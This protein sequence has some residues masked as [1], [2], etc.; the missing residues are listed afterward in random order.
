MLTHFH[1]PTRII[2]LATLLALTP[3]AAEAVPVRDADVGLTIPSIVPGRAAPELV[4]ALTLL[5]QGKVDECI[6]QTRAYLRRDPGSAPAH[7]L[8]GA[9]LALKGDLAGAVTELR[10]AV[11]LN[12]DQHTAH[13][14]LGDIYLVQ[15][16]SAEAR[17]EFLRAIEI[18]DAD[19]RAHQRLGRLFESE[20]NFRQA[21]LHFEKGIVGTPAEYVG[22]KLNLGRLYNLTGQFSGSA[23][24]LEPVVAIHPKHG[25][26]LLTLGSAY[27][28]LRRPAD[29]VRL[30]RTAASVDPTGE[31]PRVYLGMALRE[32]GAHEESVQTLE[33]ARRRHL[34]SPLP[35]LQLGE[36]FV[37]MGQ[38]AKA[39]ESFDRAA[40]LSADPAP[41]RR[42]IAEIHM[43][44]KRFAEA[45]AIY[46]A[47]AEARG[48]GV[49]AW[50]RLGTAY[51]MAGRLPDAEKTFKQMATAFPGTPFPHYRLGTFYGYIKKY[52]RAEAELRRA[53]A[54]APADGSILRALSMS[55]NE[56]GNSSA[57]VETARRLVSVQPDDPNAHFYLATLYHDERRLDSAERLYREILARWPD[58]ALTLNNL[59]ALLADQGKGDE[60]VPLAQKAVALLPDNGVI[61][62]TLGW[63][64]HKQRKSSEA[65]AILQRAARLAPRNAGVL[66]HLGVV[67]EALGDRRAAREHLQQALQL[68]REFPQA[69]DARKRLDNL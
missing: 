58:H 5:D 29:A 62:D 36:T 11:A 42:R 53:L 56:Q 23:A 18:D 20:G 68:S 26:A 61:L 63:A 40:A 46:R 39:L 43:T 57:A 44:Q 35:P 10:Q 2:V 17:R 65:L 15:K 25:P 67:Y 7:E 21:I 38:T 27:M 41:I 13:T 4:E 47:Q 1:G 59:A 66:Y 51:Q 16:K 64:V 49:D 60:A 50:D 12:P 28:G 6:A 45:I 24:L 8:L 19:H 37:R 34:K 14:K 48:A 22:V 33:E 69:A 52:D 9:A 55:Q 32:T 30:F 54:L 3:P 31:T